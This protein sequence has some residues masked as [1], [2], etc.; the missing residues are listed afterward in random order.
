MFAT[1]VETLWF[2]RNCVEACCAVVP[3]DGGDHRIGLQEGRR[4]E[5]RKQH[6]RACRCFFVFR[7]KSVAYRTSTRVLVKFVIHTLSKESSKHSLNC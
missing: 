7:S 3:R 6:V 5:S 2:R 4:C 1:R